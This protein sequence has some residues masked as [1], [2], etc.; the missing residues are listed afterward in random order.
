MRKDWG[1]TVEGEG[2]GER[3]REEFHPAQMLICLNEIQATRKWYKALQEEERRSQRPQQNMS[4]TTNVYVTRGG[5]NI[6]DC[7]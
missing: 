1:I 2:E 6:K 3:L 7:K 4:P 5:G